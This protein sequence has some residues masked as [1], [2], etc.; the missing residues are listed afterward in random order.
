MNGPAQRVSVIVTGQDELPHLRQAIESVV[1]Q[2]R[3]PDEVLLVDAGSHDGSRECMDEYADRYPELI[4]RYDCPRETN[5]PAMRNAAL[6]RVSGNLV[7]FLD[8]DDWFEPAKLERE[9]ATY[10]RHDDARLVFSDV[11]YADGEGNRNTRWCSNRSPPTGDVL[12]ETLLRRWPREMLPRSELVSRDAVRAA[13][14]YDES[15]ELYEDW[16]LKIRLAANE[17]F[18]FC[19]DPLSAYRRHEGGVS[20]LTPKS[21][22]VE[23][24]DRIATKYDGLVWD[25]FE[26]AQAETIRRGLVGLERKQQSLAAVESGRRLWGIRLYLDYLSRVPAA[27]RNYRLHVRVFAPTLVFRTFKLIRR[28]V[29]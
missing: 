3:R 23:A 8:G 6:E 13:G 14:G 5:I 26:D 11:Y 9:L 27:R 25:R 15:L 16:D 28:A 12:Y 29:R 21:T 22:Y 10:E 7:T 17:T 2:R 18:A 20:Q 1:S 19:A 4:D 24:I